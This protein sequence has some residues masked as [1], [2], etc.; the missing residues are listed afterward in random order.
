MNHHSSFIN[1]HSS[2]IFFGTGEY[3]IPVVEMLKSRGLAMVV[4]TDG[5]GAV[6]KYAR[7]GNIPLL[8][9]DLKNEEDVSKIR[10]QKPVIGVLASYGAIVSQR[11][12]D[13]FPQGIL[14]IHPSLL[15]KYKGPSPIQNAILNGDTVTGVSIIL[16]DHDV[17]H[18]PIVLQREVRLQGDETTE[19]LKN[20]LFFLGSE[21]VQEI[22]D[23]TEAI[24]GTAQ[25]HSR[26]SFTNK[27]MS[28]D[29]FIDIKNPPDAKT[30]DRMIRAYYPSPGVFFETELSEKMRRIKLLPGGKI[31]IEGKRVMSYRDF[32]NGYLDEGE[33]ILSQ[34]GLSS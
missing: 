5:T 18:G 30:L 27:V 33:K 1:N 7:T 2:I 22:V 21:M 31:Q 11:V 19:D 24:E 13:I 23:G 32:V 10:A 34:L 9:S 28:R 29:A 15:P 8:V 14:N 6:A 25:D 16:L 4:T 20:S 12:I 26:E 3:T 17:D